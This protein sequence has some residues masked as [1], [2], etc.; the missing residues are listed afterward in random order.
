ME[1]KKFLFT[2][3]MTIVILSIAGGIYPSLLTT[4]NNITGSGWTGTAMLVVVSIIFWILTASGVI[5][6]LMDGMGI[7]YGKR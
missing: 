7:K 1:P 2:I 3:I 5:L 6:F 4:I